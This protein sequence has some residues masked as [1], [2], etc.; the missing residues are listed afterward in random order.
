MEALVAN[1]QLFFLQKSNNWSDL[2]GDIFSKPTNLL[3]WVI[4]FLVIL[5][6]L[7]RFNNYLE[8]R[9]V[10]RAI[11][12]TRGMVGSLM[13]FVIA[14]IYGIPPPDIS[15]LGKWIS[16]TFSS[17]FWLLRCA[18][19]DTNLIQ[20]NP[21]ELYSIHALVRILWTLIPLT[22]IWLRV[23]KTKIG[24]LLILPVIIAILL[25]ARYKKANDTFLTQGFN[26]T[27]NEYFAK[28]TMTQDELLEEHTKI[29][30]P[31][32]VKQYLF[33]INQKPAESDNLEEL[34]KI[35]E[36]KNEQEKL[37][38]RGS[39]ISSAL[40]FWGK[41]QFVRLNTGK[42]KQQIIAGVI[43]GFILLGFGI[44]LASEKYRIVGL[45]I[46]IIGILGFFLI[47]PSSDI[48]SEDNDYHEDHP[49]NIVLDSLI[50]RMDSLYL[51]EGDNELDVYNI[52]NRIYQAYQYQYNKDG[53]H[54]IDT[55][56]DK[57]GLCY[58]YGDY[59]Y[60]HC[61]K[62]RNE[63]AKG[64][65]GTLTYKIKWLDKPRSKQ[66]KK[67]KDRIENRD[68]PHTLKVIFK[69]AWRKIEV[70]SKHSKQVF[71]GNNDT[72]DI[73]L[74]LEKTNSEKKEK[75]PNRYY[76]RL[77]IKDFE[78]YQKAYKKGLD[79]DVI[80]NKVNK[81]T[82]YKN[83]TKIVSKQEGSLITVKKGEYEPYHTSS[84]V[85]A[86]FLP[87]WQNPLCTWEELTGFMNYST[88]G[89]PILL[90]RLLHGGKQIFTL[91]EASMKVPQSF[92]MKV[93]VDYVRKDYEDFMKLAKQLW[94]W[95]EYIGSSK[96]EHCLLMDY[97]ISYSDEQNASEEDRPKIMRIST[98]Q[99]VRQIEIFNKDSTY[100]QMMCVDALTGKGVVW[101]HN[102][103]N[104]KRISTKILRSD[105]DAFMDEIVTKKP[106]IKLD[107]SDVKNYVQQKATRGLYYTA[108]AD[109]SARPYAEAYLA[110]V[111]KLTKE[112]Q[113]PL[114]E[115]EAYLKIEGTVESYP[116]WFSFYRGSTKI[117]YEAIKIEK[118]IPQNLNP[119][120][121]ELY[122]TVDMET[123][124]RATKKLWAK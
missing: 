108:N 1:F 47:T 24:R 118:A 77:N 22:L 86:K 123:M 74:L 64:F 91:K 38:R 30:F 79:Q 120:S 55:I 46:V 115:W 68:L 98:N 23:S 28:M 114:C 15:F 73:L 76:T 43:I 89:Y 35:A 3:I 37:R 87:D 69:G 101:L 105:F 67:D 63:Y 45:I 10:D 54:M 65:A 36:L 14:L 7:S 95:E 48:I 19:N 4:V 25:I 83:Q 18:F 13:F 39:Q 41:T 78:D 56:W 102:K 27:L 34:E 6:A 40:V 111:G 51:A 88:K 50:L 106:S 33:V 96:G 16:L 17:Y 100:K 92:S 59:F 84:Y 72:K 116:L 42:F 117:T 119:N 121:P 26:G 12:V 61:Y 103:K 81:V 11:Y 57:Y 5:F 52:A 71:I 112:T 113:Y 85:S 53:D 44:G 109:S 107:A 29:M 99:K 66:T 70:W 20:D 2:I 122:E 82:E 93:S 124:M 32:L 9:G 97:T 8:V 58:K 75:I 31:V 94:V 21:V 80:S 49:T 110:D 90:E 62:Q 104:N 60:D